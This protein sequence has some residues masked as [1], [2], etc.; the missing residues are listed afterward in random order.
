MI[1]T[2]DKIGIVLP[3]GGLMATESQTGMIQAMVDNGIKIDFIYA[4]SGGGLSGAIFSS[5]KDM[6]KI[7]KSVDIDNVLRRNVG[8][9][10]YLFGRP[11]YQIEGV[12]KML[13]SIIG[14]RIFK[15]MVVN[16]TDVKTKETYYAY[17]NR[18]TVIASMSIPKVFPE[19][20]LTG[21]VF[22]NIT[23]YFYNGPMKTV[24]QEYYLR[25]TPVYD[26][27]VYNLYPFPDMDKILCCKKLYCLCPPHTVSP[28]KMNNGGSLYRAIYWI[29]DTL[30][31]GFRQCLSA[32]GGLKNVEIYRPEPY[33][34]SMLNFS[35][36]F[37]LFYK[38]YNFMNEI[39]KKGEL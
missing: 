39:L 4:C 2:K 15:N 21:T 11:I 31:R 37:D 34:G 12:D 13:N 35:D 3:G 17:A 32:Y 26:G 20:V 8:V 30:E 22:R 14:D 23:P 24:R 36:N 29:Y 28:E 9:I 6:M 33:D 10:S 38:S 7:L 1:D 5:G 16:M 18:S 27:G 25:D 19:K